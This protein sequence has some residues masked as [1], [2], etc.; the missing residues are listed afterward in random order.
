MPEGSGPWRHRPVPSGL[1]RQDQAAGGPAADRSR[2]CDRRGADGLTVKTSL[3]GSL[4]FSPR[5]SPNPF[6][7]NAD[8]VND[9]VFI[10]YK[11][12]RVT[13]PVPVSVEIFDL[14]GAL[15]KQVYE[16]NDPF[17]AYAHT[18]DGTG[19]SG[20]LVPPGLYLYRIVVDF[21]TRRETGSGIL[22]VMY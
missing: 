1:L 21:Q 10:A 15:V 5:V 13:T 6:T 3:S 17:G 19:G 14:S 12:L 22:A 4:I 18:W 20:R 11:L 8:G 7:P 16:G 9:A 2:Q